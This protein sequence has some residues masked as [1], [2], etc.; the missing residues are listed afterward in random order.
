MI[1]E[2]DRLAAK[3][4]IAPESGS[5]RRIIPAA[6]WF[7]AVAAVFFW[8]VMFPVGDLLLKE[9]SMPPA[10]VGAFR[11]LFAAPILF[12]VGIC[13]RGWRAMLP[14]GARD[15]FAV[16]ALGLVGTALMAQFLFEAQRTIA[17]VNAS[18]MEAYV[19]MQ[20]LVLS[21]LGGTKISLREAASV[22]AGF[23]GS[24]LVLKALD[25]SGFRLGAIS[26]G[27]LM[28]FLSGLCWA[29]Y[30]AWGRGAAKRM[31]GL[32]FAAWTMLWGGVWLALG[33]FAA[34]KPPVPP[35]TRLEWGCM[36]FL[37]IFP[38]CIS[39]LGWNEAQKDVSLAHLSFMEYFPPV[40]A[41][42]TGVAFFGETVTRWQWLGLAVILW[43]ARLQIPRPAARKTGA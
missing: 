28:A 24:L 23:A 27:D 14:H 3:P 35:A 36:A 11:Y 38:T 25:G 22:A 29:V 16:S 2:E 18:L 7:W 31:G 21:F 39:F 4:G 43:S 32:A 8:G 6:G 20:V 42:M 15:W 1:G 12:A 26:L 33:Q 13:T 10:S 40:V 30:T 34:G 5:R 41:A 9:G 19:P 37:A 17:P